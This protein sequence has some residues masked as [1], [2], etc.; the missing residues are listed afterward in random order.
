MSSLRDLYVVTHTHWDREWYRTEQRF[1]QRLVHLITIHEQD[2][3]ALD[4]DPFES[5]LV[6]S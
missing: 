5:V 3:H 6:L 2:I 1:R 4:T